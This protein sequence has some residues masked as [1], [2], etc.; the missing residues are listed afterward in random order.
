MLLLLDCGVASCRLNLFSSLF[1]PL[2]PKLSVVVVDDARLDNGAHRL[3]WCGSV[4]I[5]GIMANPS[6]V[7]DRNANATRTK[8]SRE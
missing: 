6:E 8:V 4:P 1:H 5:F 7:D 2:I 3:T